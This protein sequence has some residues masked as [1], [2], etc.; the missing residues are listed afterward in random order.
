MTQ[1]ITQPS[2][3][4]LNMTGDITITWDKTNEADMLALVEQ[5][6]KEGFS[7]FIMK[8]RFLSILGT[9]KV[10]AES[11]EDVA[12]A[13]GARVEDAEFQRMMGRLKLHDSTIET[14]VSAG[15]AQL[16]KSDCP[17]DRSTIRRAT[18]PAEVVKSQTVAV[19]RIVGG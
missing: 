13:G 11:I 4:W 6:M 16:T 12:A 7:F 3:T 10:R 19:R 5:K 17:V 9:K 2:I 8:P 14:A 1:E 18:T 15:K